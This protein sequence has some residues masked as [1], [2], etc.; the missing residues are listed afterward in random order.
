VAGRLMAQSVYRQL[1]KY[2]HLRFVPEATISFAASGI[3]SMDVGRTAGS[4]TNCT[5]QPAST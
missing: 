2:P 4:I 3:P 5:V 1:R